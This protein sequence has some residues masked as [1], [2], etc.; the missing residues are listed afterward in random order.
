MIVVKRLA[1]LGAA[2]ALIAGALYARDQWI[3][4][5]ESTAGTTSATVLVCAAELAALCS[6]VSADYPELTVRVDDVGSSLNSIADDEMWFTFTPFPDIV[7]QT[8]E[9]TRQT[10]LEYAVSPVASSNLAA[11]SL[12]DRGA[13]LAANCGSAVEWRCL[14]D[15]AGTDWSTIGGDASWG[16]VRP[17]FSPLSSG[18]GR[19][20]VASAVSGFFG[21][22]P[23]DVN[24]PDFIG[25]ARRFDRAVPASSLAGSTAVGTIQVRSSLLD[26]AIGAAAE[27]TPSAA[28]RF[29]ASVVDPPARIDLVLAV[30]AGV[31]APSGLADA[32]AQVAESSGW[33]APGAPGVAGAPA[34]ANTVVATSQVWEDLT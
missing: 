20:G 24:N 28:P 1:A 8:R 22:A 7:S 9:R 23:I 33:L 29:T 13:V 5:D 6:Q 14:G 18:I 15:L 4:E 25:W 31:R 32:L 27:L 12:T 17:A 30:P 16:R 11:V 26:V 3:E 34:D 21:D 2:V 10:A 19:L